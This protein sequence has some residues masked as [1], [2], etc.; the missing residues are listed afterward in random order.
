[1]KRLSVYCASKAAIIG[2]TRSIAMD[3]APSGITVNAICPGHVRTSRTRSLIPAA[4][5]AMT[6]P[7]GRY[8]EARDIAATVVFLAS[9]AASFITAQAIAVDGGE[10]PA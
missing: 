9:D 5:L 8:G 4:E 2:M 1:M 10:L 3:V 7:V 6:I